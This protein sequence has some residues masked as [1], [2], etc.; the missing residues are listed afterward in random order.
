MSSNASPRRETERLYVLDVLR[1][2][3][4]LGMFLVHF[5]IFSS[6]GDAAD[7]VYRTGVYMFLEER[8]WAT[9]AILFGI[10]F[11]IQLRRADARGDS[12]VANFLRRL[13]ALAIIGFAAHAF[14]GFNVLLGYAVWG[15]PLLLVR[16]WSIRSLVVAAI[17]SAISWQVYA[18][19][20]TAYSVA[21]KGEQTT[22]AELDSS[23]A[24]YRAFNDAAMIQPDVAYIGY[25]E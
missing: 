7:E 18:I 24:R 12:F 22:R 17:V 14:F 5:S 15:L 20:T 19:G 13:A 9:F 11:A 1:G 3:A 16:R 21:T 25:R 10:G 6:G 8:A 2:M 4:L 23:A